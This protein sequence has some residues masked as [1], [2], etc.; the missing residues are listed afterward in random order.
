MSKVGSIITM[1]Y[2]VIQTNRLGFFLFSQTEQLFDDFD[3]FFAFFIRIVLMA[4]WQVCSLQSN[5]LIFLQRSENFRRIFSD[6]TKYKKYILW[7]V[8]NCQ[9]I[10]ILWWT[11]TIYETKF[12][13]TA[14]KVIPWT[15]E[16]PQGQKYFQIFLPSMFHV[17]KSIQK[18]M[19]RWTL[20]PIPVRS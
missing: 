19:N 4:S 12:F 1:K 14:I 17:R 6:V 8:R 9:E 2:K 5:Y 15:A 3:V 10:E 16:R 7:T 13:F 11:R 18:C 20:S